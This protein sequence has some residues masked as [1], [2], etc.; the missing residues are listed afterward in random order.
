MSK[1]VKPDTTFDT[2]SGYTQD[3]ICPECGGY[4]TYHKLIDEYRCNS[5]YIKGVHKSSCGWFKLK[6]EEMA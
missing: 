4:A 2:N 6:N 3:A 1:E 5:G